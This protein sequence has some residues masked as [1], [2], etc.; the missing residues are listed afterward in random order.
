MTTISYNHKDKQISCD[1]QA[2]MNGIVMD[3]NATKFAVDGN[4][5]HFFCGQFSD[6]S[7]ML[8]YYHGREHKDEIPDVAMLTVD[9]RGVVW[10]SSITSEGLLIKG[11]CDHHMTIGSGEQFALSALDFG[12][13]SKQAVEYA[14]TRCIYTGG[15]VHTYDIATKQFI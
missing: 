5:I 1:S 2:T 7:L 12:N 6:R 4:E 9:D 15:K 14:A 13:S 3:I 8:D 11:E 10:V